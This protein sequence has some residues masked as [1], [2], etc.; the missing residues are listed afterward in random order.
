VATGKNTLDVPDVELVGSA[1]GYVWVRDTGFGKATQIGRLRKLDPATGRE[2]G[3]IAFQMDRASFACG[4]LW[5]M[6]TTDIDT[7]TESTSVVRI[8]PASGAVSGRFTVPGRLEGPHDVGSECWASV[9]PGGSNPDFADYADH[10]VRLGDAAIEDTSPRIAAG[11]VRGGDPG[12]SDSDGVW[13]GRVEVQAGAFWL[14]RDDL[15][16]TATLQ[17]IDPS[18]WQ[19]SGPIWVWAHSGLPQGSPFALIDGSAWAFDDT[20]GLVRLDFPTGGA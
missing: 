1:L 3:S 7:A 12:S 8:D 19:P 16:S 11:I 15:G 10:F 17:R 4:T 18:T 6:S 2:K 9:T 5:G 20:G 13:E 14:A